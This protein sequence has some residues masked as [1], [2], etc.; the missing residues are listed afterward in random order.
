MFRRTRIFLIF[1]ILPLLF[2]VS[3][4]SAEPYWTTYENVITCSCTVRGPFCLVVVKQGSTCSVFRARNQAEYERLKP[5]VNALR[6][7]V[8]CQERGQAGYMVAGACLDVPLAE[9][10]QHQDMIAQKRADARADCGARNVDLLSET[11]TWK[12]QYQYQC[13]AGGGGGGDPATLIC[14]I[15]ECYERGLGF[16]NDLCRPSAGCPGG[17][18]ACGTPGCP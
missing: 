12:G 14:Q 10:Q 5:T 1:T 11:I 13:A 17:T 9:I 2:A 18:N 6:A 3:A 15:G 7:R 4:A 8:A 16:G